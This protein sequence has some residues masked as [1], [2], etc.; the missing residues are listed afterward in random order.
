[1]SVLLRRR[2]R[3]IEILTLNRPERRNALNT[4]LMFELGQALQEIALDIDVRAVVLTASGEQAFCAGMDLEAFASAEQG[5]GVKSHPGF[6]LLVQGRFPKPVIAAVNGSAV[7]GGFE[8]ML[9]CDLAIA[10]R[11]A[12][13]GLPEVRS[14]LFPAGGGVLLPARIPLALALEMGLTGALIDADRA[15]QLGLLNQVADAGL[16]LDAALELALQIARN[17]P[18]GVAATKQLMWRCAREGMQAASAQIAEH[19]ATVFN[20]EDAGEGARAFVEKRPAQWKG[21]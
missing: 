2:E 4:E 20:S 17:A 9:G 5:A 21:C 13:F 12:R 10:A 14:G 3:S 18:L 8:L 16:V 11:H 6:D 1:M 15:L 7:A 19:V